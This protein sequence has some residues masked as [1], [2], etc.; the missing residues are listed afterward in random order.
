MNKSQ[1]E[2]KLDW[3]YRLQFVEWL[4]LDLLAG[5]RLALY[6]FFLM[7]QWSSKTRISLTDDDEMGM[8]HAAVA[9]FLVED[10]LRRGLIGMDPWIDSV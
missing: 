7:G 2:H 5:V 6:N 3:L 1:V 9:L 10:E 4:S 8:I